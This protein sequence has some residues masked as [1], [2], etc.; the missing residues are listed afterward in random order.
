V[1][2]SYHLEFLWG[3]LW[4][5]YGK[6]QSPLTEAPIR[7]HLGP[8]PARERKKWDW[9]QLEAVEVSAWEYLVTALAEQTTQPLIFIYAPRLPYIEEGQVSHLD[10]GAAYARRFATVCRQ[11]GI[12]FIDM[13]PYF[14][15]WHEASG[16]F[17]RGFANSIPGRG[18][19]NRHGHR[20]VAEAVCDYVEEHLSH[21]V[22]AD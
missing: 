7:F 13:T 15:A 16:L 19:F 21:A 6:H 18:H 5:L 9:S 3:P 12:G 10:P 8:A 4:N 17:P 14:T 2:D 11:A 1:L 22:H 20:L